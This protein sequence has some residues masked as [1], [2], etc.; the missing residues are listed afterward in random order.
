[1]EMLRVA[2]VFV[3]GLGFV[4]CGDDSGGG[5]NDND[6][7]NINNTNNDN[8][9]QD[10]GGVQDPCDPD[11]CQNGGTC[12]AV[13]QGYECDCPSGF[14][15]TNCEIED[16]QAQDPMG[17]AVDVIFLHHSTG[18]VIFGGGVA[19]WFDD[20]NTANGT[21][22]TITEL[23]YPHSPYPWANYPYDYWYLWVD[24]AGPNP[25]EGQETLE[26][27][28]PQYPVIVF[29]HCY[30]VSQIEAD[31][32][33]PDIA[34]ERKSRE[35]YELQYAALK[36]KLLQ[37][38]DNRFIVWTGAALV[39]SATSPEAA[40]RARDFF[41]WVKNVW[42]EPG[43]NIYVWDFWQLET[44]GGL[45]LLPENSAGAGDSHPSSTFAGFAAPLFALR[46]IDV[47]DGYGD[48]RSLTGE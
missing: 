48:L 5:Q 39:E 23:A 13:G 43:D 10:D 25:A 40:G 24:N 12:S 28:T 6:N 38:P 4:G 30:P 15:G 31:T 8:N 37:F 33:A 2:M 20:Y 27:L 18:G 19:G 44:E 21:S 32:G 22:H 36:D 29:K 16:S 35:N 9:Y 17:N 42:D 46:I 1:M 41:D 7:D 14:S 47:I 3:V 11:P 26:M 45:Y 34:S